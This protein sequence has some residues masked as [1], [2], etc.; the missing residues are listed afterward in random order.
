MLTMKCAQLSTALGLLI[1]SFLCSAQSQAEPG[2]SA[3]DVLRPGGSLKDQQQAHGVR[4]ANT[5]GLHDGNNQ[6]LPVPPSVN[7]VILQSEPSGD[8]TSRRTYRLIPGLMPHQG[9][10]ARGVVMGSS[11]WDG[12]YRSH[13]GAFPPTQAQNHFLALAAYFDSC[14]AIERGLSPDQQMA[15]AV[16]QFQSQQCGIANACALGALDALTS[17]TAILKSSLVN[18]SNEQ[19]G[20]SNSG[21]DFR[22]FGEGVW[23]VQQLYKKVYF[24]MALLFALPGAILTQ[25]RAMVSRG[26][27]ADGNGG[28][29]SGLMRAL[30]GVILAVSVPL[31][32]SYAIDTGNS[33]AHEVARHTSA[34]QINQWFEDHIDS[35]FSE[36]RNRSKTN[37]NP[38]LDPQPY[39]SQTLTM[40]V[41][42][43][44]LI[45]CDG[46]LILAAF[47]TVLI[48]YLLLLGPLASCFFM[49]PAEIGTLFRPVYANWVSA[50]VHVVLW[51]FWWC[52]LT[53]CMTVRAGWLIEMGVYDPH[54]QWE[55]IMFTCFLLMMTYVPFLPFDFRVGDLID[56]LLSR[57]GIER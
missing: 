49:W 11:G 21:G 26:G 16:A 14:M 34:V 38:E 51:R 32:V 48:C 25:F 35:D 31:T 19:S 37:P 10:T 6:R 1:I 29:L 41:N 57:C 24:P 36:A 52:I 45:L 53:L 7:I 50:L 44:N 3:L 30:I 46:L 42:L 2:S 8:R 17:W 22:R 27:D 55:A 13:A 20:T 23:M 4:F 43:L 18:V 33:L 39:M 5:S 9:Q 28:P 54:C 47:Q 40:S 15:A 12:W 56:G